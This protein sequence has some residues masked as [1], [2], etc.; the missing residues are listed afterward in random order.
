MQTHAKSKELEDVEDIMNLMNKVELT[1]QQSL[2]V[3]D[4]GPRVAAHEQDMLTIK[5]ADLL[6]QFAKVIN[7]SDG[8]R[9]LPALVVSLKEFAI[10]ALLLHRLQTSLVGRPLKFDVPK[11]YVL[12]PSWGANQNCLSDDTTSDNCTLVDL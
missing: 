1:P 2:K 7:V 12:R 9:T 10:N 4:V 3:S 8:A 11:E 6:W 5:N